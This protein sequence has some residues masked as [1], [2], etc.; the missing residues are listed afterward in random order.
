L[1]PVSCI[2]PTQPGLPAKRARVEAQV[3][4]IL[5]LFSGVAC[6]AVLCNLVILFWAQNEFTQPESVV[7]AQATML[8]QDGTLYYDLNRYPY[9]V[10]AYMPIFYWLSAGLIKFGL[11]VFLAGR[12]WSFAAMIGIFV[13]T[14]RMLMLYTEDRYCAWTGTVICASTALISVWGAVAQV[15]TVAIFWTLAAFYQFSRYYVRGES[16]LVWAGACVLA[17]FFTKQT[18]LAC[19]AAIFVLLWFRNRKVALQFGAG[20]AVIAAVLAIAINTALSGR[21]LADT[22]IANMN[23]MAFE[24]LRVHAAYAVIAIGQLLII[25]AAGARPVIRS[26]SVALYVYFATAA[27][28]LALTGGKIGS[29]S[30]YQIE[31]SV[32]IILCAC[33]ALH[34]LDFFALVFSGSRLWVTLLQ[35]PLLI[36]LLLNLQIEGHLLSGRISKEKQLRKQIVA[37]RPYLADGGKLISADYNS[38]ARLHGRFDVELQVYRM[39]LAKRVIDPEQ[40]RR[41]LAASV[42]STVL[43]LQDARRA[44]PDLEIPSVTAAQLEEI[45]K[46]YKLVDHLPGPYVAGIYVYKPVTTCG[47]DD[48]VVCAARPSTP[49]H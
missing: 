47:A 43:L 38:M 5:I 4:R 46:H 20:L 30:N 24:K 15:D 26:R 13:L 14:W 21:F 7:A 32:V 48:L 27:T 8:A 45:R 42:F 34:E 3:R 33:V 19:P 23:P 36:H 44:E 35:A 22:V 49:L 12:L 9:T 40:V 6:A 41:D 16:T 39:L 17:A 1:T 25:A 29:D 31:S 2:T 28:I 37:L 10:A 11:P 18:T